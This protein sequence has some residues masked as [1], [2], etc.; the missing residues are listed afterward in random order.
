[1]IRCNQ[2]NNVYQLNPSTNMWVAVAVEQEEEEEPLPKIQLNPVNTLLPFKNGLLDLTT[3]TL[4][5]CL[6]EDYQTADRCANYEYVSP[7]YYDG[8]PHAI[9]RDNLILVWES[10]FPEPVEAHTHLCVFASLLSN[11][12]DPSVAYCRI[13]RYHQNLHTQVILLT[14]NLQVSTHNVRDFAL[15]KDAHKWNH[16][17]KRYLPCTK[18]PI[19]SFD[20]TQNSFDRDVLLDLLIGVHMYYFKDGQVQLPKDMPPPIPSLPTIPKKRKALAHQHDNH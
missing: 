5:P 15:L 14:N 6:P 16:I 3:R 20:S 18:P 10:M 19:A 1:M 4:R 8:S 17:N 12:Y 7:I 11:T 2:S 9:S 13:G